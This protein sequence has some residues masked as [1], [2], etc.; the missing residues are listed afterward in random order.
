MKN[1]TLQAPYAPIF[2]DPF[3][4]SHF[5]EDFTLS[6]IGKEFFEDTSEFEEIKETC[7][8]D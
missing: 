6:L 3:N 2:K 1:K 4:L 7:W 8:L 5:S